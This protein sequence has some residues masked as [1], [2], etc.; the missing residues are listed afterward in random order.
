MELRETD[1][2]LIDAV[3]R[4]AE[5]LC[6]EAL[7]LI[8][9]YG[10]VLTGET[11]EKSDLDLAI[12]IHDEAGYA[13]AQGFLLED[14][15]IGY[16]LYCTTWEAMEQM[17]QYRDPQIAKLMD[18]EIVYRRNEAA[19]ARLECLR[20]DCA[21][22]LSSPFSAADFAS[23][24]NTLRDAEHDYARV[25][26]ADTL[27][28]AR[29]NAFQAIQH[30]MDA[31]MLAAKRY[32]RK[33]VHRV[34]AE[35]RAAGAPE[36][37]RENVMAVTAAKTPE[38]VQ[39]SLTALMR[40]MREFEAELESRFTAKKQPPMPKALRGT[41][42]EM[43]SNWAGKMLRAERS[44]DRWLAFA[45]MSCFQAMLDEIGKGTAIPAFEVLTDYDPDDLAAAR[46]QFQ[47]HLD[48]YR[49]FCEACGLSICRY[50]DAQSFLQAYTESIE[51]ICDFCSLDQSFA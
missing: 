23:V 18:S 32:Y 40:L 38:A 45:S 34:F 4:R 29:L 30:C 27:S 42:E 13:L 20:A 48:R 33:G 8:A 1:R 22:R 2:I 39:R 3:I 43:C 51:F 7:D 17:A 46:T 10:S 47:A 16:D 26:T 25:M 12:V 24:R 11:W 15:G 28:D 9:V 36:G 35:L 19:A 21:K 44:G 50:P 41:Y 14:T 31:V 37:F 5:R 49:A 6:P